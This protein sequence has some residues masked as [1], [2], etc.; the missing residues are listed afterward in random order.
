V[1]RIRGGTDD[2]AQA[3]GARRLTVLFYEARFSSH[4]LGAD[5]RD[6]ATRALDDLAAE[7]GDVAV[8]QGAP[9]ERS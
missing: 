9:G 7:L 4:P 6:A 3:N 2:Q 1:N 8:P 5:K